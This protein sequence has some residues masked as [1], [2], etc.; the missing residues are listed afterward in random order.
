MASRHFEAD[1]RIFLN[2]VSALVSS[3]WEKT[4][5]KTLTGV[6]SSISKDYFKPSSTHTHC[7]WKGT[8]SYYDVEAN[9][10]EIKDA[11]W[12]YPEPMEGAK[13]IKDYVAFCEY[14]C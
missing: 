8:A 13:H 5:F 1:R 3:T 2:T 4:H 10:K 11:A 14:C 6:R 9:G 7:G 12:Y